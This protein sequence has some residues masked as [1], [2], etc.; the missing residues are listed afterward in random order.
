VEAQTKVKQLENS[1]VQLEL[2]IADHKY[3]ISNAVKE[4]EFF[5]A[6]L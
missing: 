5:K 3:Q 6:K 4:G 2:Q 1:K